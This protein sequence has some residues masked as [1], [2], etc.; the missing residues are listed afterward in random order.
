MNAADPAEPELALEDEE[1]PVPWYT[2]GLYRRVHERRRHRAERPRRI[3]LR[4]RLRARG[5]HWNSELVVGVFV[6]VLVASLAAV[7]LSR[8][9]SG[10]A[11]DLG[12]PTHSSGADSSVPTATP[13]CAAPVPGSA[14]RPCT[15]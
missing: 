3:P 13:Q 1:Q 10:T 7:A 4:E 14:M 11:N 9:Q 8:I 15:Y 12:I 6:A 5:L 2:P